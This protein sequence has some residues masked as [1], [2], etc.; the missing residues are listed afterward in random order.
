MQL[1]CLTR[2]GAVKYV[3]CN[4]RQKQLFISPTAKLLGSGKPPRVRLQHVIG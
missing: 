4:Q 3:S 1:N 2:V